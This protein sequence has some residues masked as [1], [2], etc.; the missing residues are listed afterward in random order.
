MVPSQA[1]CRRRKYTQLLAKKNLAGILELS[2]QWP[3]DMYMVQV[4]SSQPPGPVPLD[5]GSDHHQAC[6]RQ[7]NA[8][9]EEPA[10]RGAVHNWVVAI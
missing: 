6:R 8:P 9:E 7:S 5:Y 2:L 3:E 4:L 1:E 10:Q